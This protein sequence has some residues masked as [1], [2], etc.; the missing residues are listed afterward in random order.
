MPAGSAN[1]RTPSFP[2]VIGT[3]QGLAN[4]I[5]PVSSMAWDRRHCA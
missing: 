3:V 2:C 4:C 5:T 1:L